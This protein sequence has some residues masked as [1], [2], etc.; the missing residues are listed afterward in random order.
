M[1][2]FCNST[3][4]TKLKYSFTKAPLKRGLMSLKRQDIQKWKE[5]REVHRE[6]TE[7]G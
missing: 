6:H 7:A 2:Y 5:E 1:W 3:S 4:I